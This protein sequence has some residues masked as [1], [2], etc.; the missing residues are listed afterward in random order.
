MTY[1]EVASTP[2]H[3]QESFLERPTPVTN[4]FDEDGT[5]FVHIFWSKETPPV[6]VASK[7]Q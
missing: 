5:V 7:M 4:Y 2:G 1:D 3:P 6:V